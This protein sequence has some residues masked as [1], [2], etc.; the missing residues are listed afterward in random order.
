M[1]KLLGILGLAL[2]MVMSSP[3]VIAK[4]NVAV[5]KVVKININKASAEELST[6]KGI[7]K[8]KAEAIVTFRKQN[9]NFKKVEDI[10]LVKGIGEK[11]FA[12]IKGSITVS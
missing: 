9:G 11:M 12:K 10:M 7:G 1:K 5:K 8:K 4:D 6:L 2:V 3:S